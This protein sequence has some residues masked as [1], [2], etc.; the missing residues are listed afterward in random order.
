MLLMVLANHTSGKTFTIYSLDQDTTT[1]TNIINYASQDLPDLLP[2]EI[3]TY[4]PEGL[5][6]LKIIL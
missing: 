4:L 2:L 1:F 5:I 6:I 3:D